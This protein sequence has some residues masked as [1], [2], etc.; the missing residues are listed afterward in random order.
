[1]TKNGLKNEHTC[2]G[3]RKYFQQPT[4]V[5]ALAHEAHCVFWG[6]LVLGFLLVGK[7]NLC[8]NKKQYGVTANHPT[9]PT[10]PVILV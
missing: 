2:D 10:F 1:M 4:K 3:H 7:P 9:S 8:G 6:W 5:L